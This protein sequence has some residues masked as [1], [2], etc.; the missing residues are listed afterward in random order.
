MFARIAANVGISLALLIGLAA[1]YYSY[2]VLLWLVSL[3]A[4]LIIYSL[5]KWQTTSVPENDRFKAENESRKTITEI[6]GAA[7]LILGLYFSWQ[8]SRSADTQAQLKLTNDIRVASL[9]TRSQ[10]DL[11]NRQ[12]ETE[13][14]TALEQR[15]MELYSKLLGLASERAQLYTSQLNAELNAK[16]QQRFYKIATEQKLAEASLHM[17]EARSELRRSEQLVSEITNANERLSETLGLIQL[18]F[19]PTRQLRKLTQSVHDFSTL[20]MPDPPQELDALQLETWREAVLENLKKQALLQY[21]T[22]V[23]NLGQYLEKVME[24]EKPHKL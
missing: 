23:E 5:P 13:K 18:S 21:R 24:A 2:P 7:G 16:V 4:L 9:Q 17:D 8:A 22:P 6:L 10:I 1:W 19:P 14:A 3:P 11:L 20:N 15:R 12:I